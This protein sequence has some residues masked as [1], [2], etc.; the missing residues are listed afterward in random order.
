MQVLSLKSS[1]SLVPS[2]LF[3]NIPHTGLGGLKD[4]QV[5]GEIHIA[6]LCQE[7][8]LLLKGSSKDG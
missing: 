2:I 1:A 7:E 3:S 8:A 6:P 5:N 4:L